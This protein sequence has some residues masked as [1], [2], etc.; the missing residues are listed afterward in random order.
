[1]SIATRKGDDSTTGLLYGQRV[2]K[3]HP[4][5]EALGTFDHLNVEIGAA[6]M[7]STD[8]SVR[9]V[10][11]ATQGSLVAMMGEIA[12]AEKDAAKHAE[13]KFARVKESDLARLDT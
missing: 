10:L 12:C 7:L 6:R 8:A 5:I 9:E 3:D 11:L 1:M 4:Q 2:R 13:S